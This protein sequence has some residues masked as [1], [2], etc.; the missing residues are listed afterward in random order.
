MLHLQYTVSGRLSLSVPVIV[1]ACRTSQYSILPTSFLVGV[2]A[3]DEFIVK[4][5]RI[6]WYVSVVASGVRSVS[7]I[8]QCIDGAGYPSLAMQV[9]LAVL[10]S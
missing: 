2:Y 8:R 5:P 4:V 9:Q 10:F 6:S 1:S 3:N 7:P